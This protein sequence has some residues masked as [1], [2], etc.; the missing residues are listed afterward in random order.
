MAERSHARVKVVVDDGIAVTV[1]F[2]CFPSGKIEVL[3]IVGN[4]HATLKDVIA[5]HG[6]ERVEI[7]TNDKQ[8]IVGKKC[9]ELVVDKLLVELQLVEL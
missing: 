1:A 9:S 3:C 5:A 8:G 2:K 4:H 7:K 6:S